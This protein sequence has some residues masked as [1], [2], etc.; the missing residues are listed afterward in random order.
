MNQIIVTCF[1]E[2]LKGPY[3]EPV[4]QTHETDEKDNSLA[5]KIGKMVLEASNHG[6]KEGFDPCGGKGFI[7]TVSF[8]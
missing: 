8:R 5:E 1:P 2:G 6:L 3:Y 7:V 4:V